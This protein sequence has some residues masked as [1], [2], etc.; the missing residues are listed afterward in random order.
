MIVL[1]IDPGYAIVGWGLVEFKNNSFRPL[2]YGAIT[3]EADTDFNERLRMI[4]DDL[5][6]VIKTFKPDAM[7]IEKLY[8]TTNQKTAIMVAEARGVILLCA[9]QNGL[10]IFEYTPLQVKTAVTGYGKAKK[11][12]V[13]EMTRRLLKLPEVPKPDDTADA[14]AIALTHI[15]ATGSELRQKLYREGNL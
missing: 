6:E 9:K 7:S 8:F 10:P 11:P 3:T 4:F 15:Q 14:L 1:G 5:S 2:R 12:Q 13:M